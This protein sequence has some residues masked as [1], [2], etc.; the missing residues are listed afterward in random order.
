MKNC[1]PGSCF[2]PKRFL[3]VIDAN[4][5]LGQGFFAEKKVSSEF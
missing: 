5:I 3:T 2:M 4:D 1:F